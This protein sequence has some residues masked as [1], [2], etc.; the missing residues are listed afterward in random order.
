MLISQAS[1]IASRITGIPRRLKSS[2]QIPLS[3]NSRECGSLFRCPPMMLDWFLTTSLKRKAE[4][5]NMT[6]SSAFAMNGN[7]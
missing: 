1:S 7:I 3:I 6:R 2:G 4:T 5:F